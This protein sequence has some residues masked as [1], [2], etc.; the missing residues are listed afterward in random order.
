MA[1]GF[2]FAESGENDSGSMSLKKPG[3]YDYSRFEATVGRPRG[4]LT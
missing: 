3:I 2:T 1:G 4:Y